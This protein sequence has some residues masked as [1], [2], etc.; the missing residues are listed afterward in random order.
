M[1]MKTI[2][3]GFHLKFCTLLGW[4][5]WV[6]NLL[7]IQYNLEN[8]RAIYSFQEDRTKILP[9]STALFLTQSSLQNTDKSLQTYQIDEN[10]NHRREAKK[11]TA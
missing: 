9:K 7:I 10:C 2:E 6:I 1:A 3:M 8:K 11:S 5:I 4:S